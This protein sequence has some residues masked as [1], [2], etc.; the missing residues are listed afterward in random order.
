MGKQPDIPVTVVGAG[1]YGLATAAH[2]RARKVPLRVFGEPMDSWVARMPVGMFL[3]STPR[4]SSIAAP[5]PYGR[6]QD[7][8][9]EE[10]RPSGEDQHPVPID[11]FIRYGQWFQQNQVPELE[12]ETVQRISYRQSGFT[13]TLG[14]G[15]T[16]GSR[17]VVLATGLGPYPYLPPVLE[18]LLA[19]GRVSHSAHHPDLRVFAGRRVAVVGAG[20]SALESA[21]LLHEAGAQPTLVARTRRL[22]FGEPPPTDSPTDRP[23]PVRLVKPASPLG[24]GWS[25]VAFAHAPHAYRYLPQETRARLLHSVLG[26][27]GAW[28]LRDRVDGRFAQLTGRSLQRAVADGSGSGSG[29]SSVRLELRGAAGHEEVLEVDHVLAATGYRVDVDRLELLDP[30]LRRALTCTR[31]AP[32]L[33]AEFESSVP[34]L[35]FTGL[36]AAATFG[37]VLRFVCGTGFAARRISAAVVA[38]GRR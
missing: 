22:L 18:P 16:F 6:L 31:G 5:G 8:R 27:S 24:P 15:E 20:Q 4:A 7:F 33:S 23:L 32:L 25:L 30:A 9:A 35:Y 14:S 13:I 28:W 36:S 38:S 12:R 3:K 2:L 37:P 26:P 19:D 34:G 21:A 29:D 10:G 17:R 11:E 1:P